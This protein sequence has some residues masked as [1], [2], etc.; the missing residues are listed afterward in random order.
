MKVNSLLKFASSCWSAAFCHL[1]DVSIGDFLSVKL[2]ML[3]IFPLF[4]VGIRESSG[5]FGCQSQSILPEHFFCIQNICVCKGGGH[6]E[7][8]VQLLFISMRYFNLI[9]LNGGLFYKQEVSCQL[10]CCLHFEVQS[11]H[12]FNF[13][14]GPI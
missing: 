1:A 10:V 8:N 3:L 5:G 7:Y 11:C 2:L 12:L 6:C 14:L 9:I 4:I 13:Q